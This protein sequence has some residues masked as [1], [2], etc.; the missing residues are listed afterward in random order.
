MFFRRKAVIPPTFAER[1]DALRQAGF[2]VE[3]LGGARARAVRDGCAA[4][5]AEGPD[6]APRVVESAGLLLDGGIAALIDGGYQKFFQTPDGRRK[7]ALA[8]D[9]K[10]IHAFQ[11][12][13]R[14]TLGLTSLYNESLGTV[15]N[16]Y[17]YDRVED[18]DAGVPQRPWERN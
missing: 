13:L 17:L 8:E 1:L 14:E 15:S 4:T 18:R 5:L 7:P 9:L 11:E 2:A 16:K 10:A 6:G 3:M 12:D